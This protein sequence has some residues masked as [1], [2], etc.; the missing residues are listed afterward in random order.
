M[1]L[2]LDRITPPHHT[3]TAHGLNVE[4][5]TANGE[6]EAVFLSWHR[7]RF[8]GRHNA[9]HYA[10]HRQEVIC[11]ADASPTNVFSSFSLSLSLSLPHEPWMRRK[12]IVK[13]R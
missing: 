12:R 9:E 7:R 8:G 1:Y 3:C 13:Q 10:K 11:N 6:E 5:L 2:A 4:L